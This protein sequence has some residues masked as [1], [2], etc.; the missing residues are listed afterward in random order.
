MACDAAALEVPQRRSSSMQVCQSY[1]QS[2]LW[3]CE[4]NNLPF[5]L[6]WHKC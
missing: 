6:T 4:C 1:L 2:S 5:L 3:L